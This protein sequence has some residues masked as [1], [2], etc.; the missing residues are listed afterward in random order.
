MVQYERTLAPPSDNSSLKGKSDLSKELKELDYKDSL[1]DRPK[2]LSEV[3]EELVK[4][5]LWERFCQWVTSTENRLYIGWFGLIMIPT[6]LTAATVF[7]IAFIAAP[8]VDIN[9]SGELLSGALLDGN[10]VITAAVVPTSAAIGLHFYPIW[11][12]A[13]VDEWL[14]N[15]GPYQL[16]VLHFLIG[17]ICYQDRE[18]ELSYRLGM[19]PW[20]SLAFTA[21]VAAAVSVFLIYPI[22]QGSFSA[23]MPLGISGTFNFMLLFQADHNILMN[24]FHQ[25]GVIGVLGGSILSAMHGSLV[26]STLIRDTHENES[27]NRGYQLGQVKPT[28]GFRSIQQYMWR[29]LW[30]R[31]SFPSSRALH[32]LLA[33]LPVA[34]IWSAAL[35]IDL[36]AFDFDKLNFSQPIIQSQGRVINTWMDTLTQ[37]NMGIEVVRDRNIYTFPVDLMSQNSAQIPLRIAVRNN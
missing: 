2:R 18:W 6:L 37:A 31:G 20:I 14:Y 24:P 15:G 36:A 3:L 30:W 9:G 7:I 12:A 25:L 33:A 4:A 32:V 22:G 34:G 8:S 17:I 28:Y 21:P 16:I 13:S 29:L 23:G 11:E 35:G 1:F 19:R 5:D 26:T 27:I 10:N